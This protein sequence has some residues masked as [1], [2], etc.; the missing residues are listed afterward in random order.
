MDIIFPVNTKELRKFNLKRYNGTPPSWELIEQ[1]VK[2]SKLKRLAIFENVWEMPN[3]TLSLYKNSERGLPV[4]YW[5][6]FYDF[7]LINQKYSKLHTKRQNSD[8]KPTILSTNKKLLNAF[9]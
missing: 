2:K 1:V 9:Q 8:K 6:I 4:K 7:D 5:H 3:D